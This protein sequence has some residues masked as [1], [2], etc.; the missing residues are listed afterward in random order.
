[1]AWK[2]KTDDGG[3]VVL[4][5]GIPVWTD[6]ET[7]REGS[8]DVNELHSKILATGKEAKRYREEVEAVKSR[9]EPVNAIEDLAQFVADAEKAR[10]T[11]AALE[12]KDVRKA[13]TVEKIKNEMRAGFAEKEQKIRAEWERKLSER[14]AVLKQ[15]EAQIRKLTIDAQFDSCPLFSGTEPKTMLTSDVAKDVFGKHFDLEPGDDGT[16]KVVARLNGEPIYSRENV[17][18]PATFEEAIH[19]IWDKYPMRDHYTRSKGG[20]SG[21]SGGT[22]ISSGKAMSIP[23]LQ[24]LLAKTQNPAQAVAIE[25]AIFT[26][27]QAERRQGGG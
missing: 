10:E 9:Y 12:E 14:E 11:I 15:R 2:V 3:S 7:G 18:E 16:Q 20:G 13:E 25:N 26:A 1:M 5:D 21:A 8:F 6:E 27:Q 19:I 17:G 24:E 23:Q 4:K 22:G